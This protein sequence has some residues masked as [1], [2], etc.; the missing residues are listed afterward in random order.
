MLKVIFSLITLV[1]LSAFSSDDHKD[2]KD[3]HKSEHKD[4]HENDHKDEHKDEHKGEHKD[5][6]DDEK[7]SAGHDDHDDH[8]DHKEE[9]KPDGFKLNAVSMK[10]FELKFVKYIPQKTIVSKNAVYKGL[11]EVNLYRVRAGVFK[12]IDFNILSKNNDSYLVSSPDLSPGDEIVVHGIGFLR[13]AEI[14]ASGGLSDSHS[15]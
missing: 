12:R 4:E 8:D 14:A 7:K 11:N 5:D 13:I 15:H 3:E 6:H 2:H 9:N 1:S 10:T